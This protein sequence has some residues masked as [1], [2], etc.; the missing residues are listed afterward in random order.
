MNVFFAWEIDDKLRTYFSANLEDVAELVFIDRQDPD[1]LKA[2]VTDADIIVGWSITAEMLESAKKLKVLIVPAIGVDRHV[3]IVRK[4]KDVKLA[5]SHGNAKPTAEF[6]VALLLGIAKHVVRFD[7]RMR[8]GL[9][10]AYDDNPPS[11]LLE[12]RNVGILGTGHVGCHIATLLSGFSLRLYG[13]SRRG[14]CGVCNQDMLM[15][16]RDNFK[17]FLQI[18]EILFVCLPLTEDTLG[19]IAAEEIAMLPD[20]AFVI[21]VARGP[22]IDE[23]ALFESLKSG[24]LGGAGLDVWYNYR[25]ELVNGKKYPYTYPFHELENVLLSPHRAGSPLVRVE[26]FD[27][28]I[29]NIR[30]YISSGELVTEVDLE[31]G[32]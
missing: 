27:D 4:R 31:H 10:R 24:K 9:W 32:Y 28:V 13:C 20:G 1:I 26:R 17:E 16:S 8:S 2:A 6:A 29:E 5:N 7:S 25:P 21:N 3:P 15:F 19:M 30:S 11:M 18:C 14:K 23:Q 22:V 12:N